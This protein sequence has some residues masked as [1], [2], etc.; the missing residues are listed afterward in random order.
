MKNKTIFNLKY[1]SNLY[2]KL[3]ENKLKSIDSRIE[4][5]QDKIQQEKK[6]I[7]DSRMLLDRLEAEN[8]LLDTEYLHH[9]DA[10]EKGGKI[11]SVKNY[12]FN[13]S[14]WEN[15]HLKK[16]S[17]CYVLQTRGEQNIYTFNEDMNDFLEYLLTLN[18]SII[19]LSV[20]KSRITLQFRTH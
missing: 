11:I 14:Q 10:F 6:A 13:I 18:Y 16:K 7:E 2:I 12:N 19:V 17:P 5:L 20:D 4:K 15:L 9:L 8:T 3:K 1:M